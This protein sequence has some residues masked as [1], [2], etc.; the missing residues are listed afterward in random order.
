[1]STKV[2]LSRTGAMVPY[3]R[4]QWY[5]R[6]QTNVHVFMAYTELELQ[7]VHQFLLSCPDVQIIVHERCST[8]SEAK[9]SERL[10]PEGGYH[11]EG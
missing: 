9:A 7:A 6:G 10:Q 8:A 1:M 3:A 4:V 5:V 2:V 11:G